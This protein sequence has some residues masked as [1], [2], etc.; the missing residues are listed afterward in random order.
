MSL[1]DQQK[2]NTQ[3]AEQAAHHTWSRAKAVFLFDACRY[4]SLQLFRKPSRRAHDVFGPVYCGANG[5][6]TGP[7]TTENSSE[8]FEIQ[9]AV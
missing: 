3:G 4:R 5:N 1:R 9:V 2:P 6:S 8:C 7:S